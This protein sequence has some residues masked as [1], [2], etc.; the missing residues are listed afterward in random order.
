[1]PVPPVALQ[2][3]PE[4]GTPL[5][6]L[7]TYVA[8]ALFFSLTAHLAARYVLGDVPPARAL[9]VGAVLALVAVALVRFPPPVI[10]L[11]ALVVDFLAIRTVYRLAYRTTALVTVV[12]YTVTL[13][14]GLVITYGLRILSTAPV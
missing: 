11:A 9:V 1:M 5:A 12:H 2:V 8:T 14:G 6:F 10:L 7:G 13:L 4:P 3:A